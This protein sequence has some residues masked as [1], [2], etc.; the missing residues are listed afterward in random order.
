[1]FKTKF[2]PDIEAEL[3]RI[4]RLKN[5]TKET[6]FKRYPKKLEDFYNSLK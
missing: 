1:M 4:D 2:K 3:E 5:T 6:I